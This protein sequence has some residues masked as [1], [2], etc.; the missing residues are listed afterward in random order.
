MYLFKI[1][2]SINYLHNYFL[3]EINFD[4]SFVKQINVIPLE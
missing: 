2:K 1:F 4:P 3:Q